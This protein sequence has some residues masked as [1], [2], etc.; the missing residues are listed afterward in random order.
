MRVLEQEL[1]VNPFGSNKNKASE[2]NPE[3]EIKLD[4]FVHE[5]FLEYQKLKIEEGLN[6]DIHIL[7][8][9]LNTLKPAEIDQ[10]LQKITKS[11]PQQKLT[12]R[13]TG[14]FISKLITDS[15]LSH[16]NN[17][18]LNNGNMPLDYLAFWLQGRSD[19]LIQLTI[20]GNVKDFCGYKLKNT[21]LVIHGN[22][23]ECFVV[24][25]CYSQVTLLGN[26]GNDCGY[27][28]EHNTITILGE[29]GSR[30]GQESKHCTYRT[31]FPKTYAAIVEKVPLTNTV[32]LI[33]MN[34]LVLRETKK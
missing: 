5:V 27:Q 26:C 13:I 3:I 11:T 6:Y 10:I 31:L 8:L 4:G 1:R 33:D 14:Y 25:S 17:F 16:Y 2:E 32:Q 19:D 12:H 20:H 34:G 29:I 23:E 7:K 24:N 30:F 21:T 28:S 9:K 22:A 15:Y 18:V